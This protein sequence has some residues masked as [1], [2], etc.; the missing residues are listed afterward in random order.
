MREMVILQEMSRRLAELCEA[1]ERLSRDMAQAED[2][3]KQELEERLRLGLRGD[4]AVRHYNKWM[5]AHG[6]GHLAIDT[7]DDQLI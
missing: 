7:G 6:M 2:V 4:D 5:M 3:Y 1:S